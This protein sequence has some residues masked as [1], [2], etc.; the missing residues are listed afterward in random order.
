MVEM[1]LGQVQVFSMVEEQEEDLAG[2]TKMLL[3]YRVSV[4]EQTE[5]LQEEAAEEEL[6]HD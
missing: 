3:C 4:V 6:D 1:E 5:R 2:L